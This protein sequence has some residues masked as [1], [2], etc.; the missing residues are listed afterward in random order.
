MRLRM[1]KKSFAN[2][3]L[4]GDA[5]WLAQ[6]AMVLVL[7]V[8]TAGGVFAQSTRTAGARYTPN[9]DSDFDF[10]AFNGTIRYYIGNDSRVVIPTQIRG[11]SVTEIGNSAFENNTTITEVFIPEGIRSIGNSAFLNSNLRW[12]NMNEAKG[13]ITSIGTRAFEGTK[14]QEM[15]SNWPTAIKKI[16]NNAFYRTNLNKALVI[17]D[18]ITEIGDF[19]F[20]STQIISVTLPRTVTGIGANA[21]MDCNQLTSVSIPDVP[22]GLTVIGNA[23]FAGNQHLKSIALP[24]SINRIGN[25]AFFG[26]ISLTT[27]TIPSS[28]TRITFGT[29]AFFGTTLDSASKKALTDRG[30][31]F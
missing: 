17:P 31:R 21:F 14:L 2:A 10:N 25:S 22:D 24:R 8:I 4:F 15:I 29:D 23:A 20:A 12:I 3:N 7:T 27:V 19:A 9:P 11:R 5:N 30:A 13:T 1:E 16:P 26:C 6:L 18:E 28:V